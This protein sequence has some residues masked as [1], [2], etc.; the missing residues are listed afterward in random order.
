MSVGAAGNAKSFAILNHKSTNGGN[1]LKTTMEDQHKALI[2]NTFD[3]D[4]I[5]KDSNNGL[6]KAM[7]VIVEDANVPITGVTE[8]END[9]QIIDLIGQHIREAA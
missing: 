5:T 4:N 3:L 8:S 9:T 6:T 1:K 2:K 7:K